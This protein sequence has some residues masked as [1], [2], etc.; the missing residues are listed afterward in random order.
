MSEQKHI[1]D[2]KLTLK[3]LIISL[4]FW[5]KYFFSKWKHFLIAVII[6]GALGAVYSTIKKPLFHARTS[7]V[8]EEA[9]LGGMGQV[10][11]L[12]SLVGVNLGSLGSSSGLFKG[13]NIIELYRSNQMLSK[14]ILSPF[15]EGGTLIDRYIAFNELEDKWKSKV[16]ISRMDFSKDRSLFTVSQ[17]S[18]VKEVVKLIREKHLVVEKPNRKLTII[19]VTINSKDEKFAKAFNEALVEK[20]N[21]FYFDTKT[22]KTLE[23]LQILQSQA[24]SVRQVLNQS[25]TA[26]ASTSDK[27]PNPN[28]LLLTGTVE[29]KKKQI[30]VQASSAIYSEIVKNLELA[31]V[32]H[33]NNS[34]L[35]QII[36]SPRFPLDRTEVRLFKGVVLGAF[37]LFIVLFMMLFFNR[38]Y[39]DQLNK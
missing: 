11:G 3:E 32:N 1:I 22:K 34:P 16:D 12:A 28:P 29:S 38:L 4:N 8:L 27:V 2:D 15:E 26:F 23:N 18:V 39:K 13:D 9:D 10:S 31:K 30:D 35:I 24:D 36:D 5:L 19:E 25:L 6:G 37:I 14:A 17:D 20:V 21:T 7:F 33:R